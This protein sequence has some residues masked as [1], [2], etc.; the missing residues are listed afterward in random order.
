MFTPKHSLVIFCLWKISHNL[1]MAAVA[2]SM[3][4]HEY[5]NGFGAC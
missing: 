4:A 3:T 5:N 1:L 2:V